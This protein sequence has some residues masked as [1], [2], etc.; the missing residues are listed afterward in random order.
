MTADTAVLTPTAPNIAALLGALDDVVPDWRI[1][2]S[3]PSI[4]QVRDD[5]GRYRMS[6]ETP[7]YV[8]I[9]GEGERLLGREPATVPY[10]WTEVRSARDDESSEIGR[11]IATSLASTLGGMTVGHT[12]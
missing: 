3:R 1:D 7:S 10:F 5:T 2:A 6:I 9:R 11:T 4:I 8:Q 12:R